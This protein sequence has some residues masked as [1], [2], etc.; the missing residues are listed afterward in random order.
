MCVCARNACIFPQ[1]FLI[2]N[3]HFY[4]IFV[5]HRL[6]LLLLL[7]VYVK[8]FNCAFWFIHEIGVQHL[9]VWRVEF[10]F[11][12]RVLR[13]FIGR[14]NVGGWPRLTDGG[15]L[16]WKKCS[17]INRRK[18][19]IMQITRGYDKINFMR[20]KQRERNPTDNGVPYMSY[21]SYI[22]N[23]YLIILFF[24]LLIKQNE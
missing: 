5:S 1:T 23:N 9:R 11:S 21:K 6:M 14:A 7:I 20:K 22:N 3:K 19:I 24:M 15:Y 8:H 2:L 18:A 10:E 16:N 12:Q 17:K 4:W 13:I